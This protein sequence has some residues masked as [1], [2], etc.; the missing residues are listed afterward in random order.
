MISGLSQ[1][2]SLIQFGDNLLLANSEHKE[3]VEYSVDGERVRDLTLDGY[4]RG[5]HV[6]ESR[7]YVGLSKSRNIS[8]LGLDTATVVVLDRNNWKELERVSLPTNEIYSILALDP[9]DMLNVM[10]LL[11]SAA[12][13]RSKYFTAKLEFKSRIY[14]R[15]LAQLTRRLIRSNKK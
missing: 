8:V 6:T 13:A 3:L 11:C 12:C 14:G 7:I 15:Y 1:P 10:S 4:T 9:I 2:H 5:I